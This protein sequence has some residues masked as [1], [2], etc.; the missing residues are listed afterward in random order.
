MG[1]E[2][3]EKYGL[4]GSVYHEVAYVEAEKPYI[5]T[6]LIT[7]ANWSPNYTFVQNVALGADKIV[8]EY[9]ADSVPAMG[10]TDENGIIDAADAS[11]VLQE[12]SMLSTGNESILSDRQKIAADINK[13][14]F[15]DASDSSWILS[16]YS[17]TSTGG[18]MSF[19]DFIIS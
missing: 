19:E 2:V 14:G 11:V 8:S 3:A 18:E 9:Y 5:V 17:Y 6:I 15:I 7:T 4:L 12:Y 13:D 10:D 16:F 1:Y